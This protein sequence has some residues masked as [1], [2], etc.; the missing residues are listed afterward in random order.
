MRDPQKT[1]ARSSSWDIC[2]ADCSIGS[3]KKAIC[4]ALMWPH[5]FK[6]ATYCSFAS[7][8]FILC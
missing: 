3:L 7:G 5:I 1:R 8:G 2:T 4:P 6:A